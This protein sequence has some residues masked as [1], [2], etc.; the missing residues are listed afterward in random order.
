MGNVTAGGI[1][2][3]TPGVF[4]E[5]IRQRVRYEQSQKRL[6]ALQYH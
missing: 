2:L 5:P 3:V 6:Y 4:I 1:V